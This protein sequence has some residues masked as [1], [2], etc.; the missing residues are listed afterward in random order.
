MCWA[1][2]RW[3]RTTCLFSKRPCRL[4]GRRAA[5]AAWTASISELVSDLLSS[6]RV[7]LAMG[8]AHELPKWFG[9]VHPQY[10][11]PRHAVL[12]IGLFVF[13]VVLLFD[14]REVLP[15]ASFFLLVWFSI[16]HFSAL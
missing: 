8:E 11:V 15:L 1:Q 12:A 6:S 3:P 13:A 10:K 5:G 2:R 16:T 7:A 4:S 9:E 14:L